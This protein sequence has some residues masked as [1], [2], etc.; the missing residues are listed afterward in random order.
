MSDH[1]I[2]L[3][4][5]GLGRMG[6]PIAR[7]LAA[8]GYVTSGY[9]I[10]AEAMRLAQESGIEGARSPGEIAGATDATLVLVGS[11]TEV[12]HVVCEPDSGILAKATAGHI[13]L[14]GSTVAPATSVALAQ[15]AE[16]QSVHVVDATLCRGEGPA[17]DGTLLILTGGPETVLERVHDAL[18]VLGSSIHRLG[19]V[20]AGQVGKMLNNYLLWLTV[21]G[22]FEAMRLA[23]RM[24]V[25]LEVLRMALLESSGANWALETWHQSRPMPWA[26]KDM[27][28]L[29]DC[30][31]RFRLPMVV[32][33]TV[34][35]AIKQVKLDK[36]GAFGGEGTLR[37]MDEFVRLLELQ[38]FPEQSGDRARE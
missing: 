2:S 3:G 12:R 23:A 35:E 34:R 22:N 4:V 14:I 30:A 28:I 32:A 36:N 18:G 37:S 8:A 17:A 16:P 33:G 9:D 11:D 19:P 27:A 7:R 10:S 13:V 21:V 38:V 15:A 1:R 6:L 31:D 26:E 25:D 5:V 20:G 29:L 24:G